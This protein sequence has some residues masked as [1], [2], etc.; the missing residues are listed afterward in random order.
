MS[1][2]RDERR[3]MERKHILAVNGAVDF[4]DLLRELLQD[5]QYNVTTT[6]FVP[7]TFQQIDALQPDLII[8]DLVIGQRAGW[9]LLERLQQEAATRQIPVIVTST[10]PKLLELAKEQQE[11]FGRKHFLAKPFELDDLLQAVHD[12]IGHA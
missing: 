10:D 11:K 7:G 2:S 3:Q 5:E 12:L 1:M 4:L 8:I 9:D 6:N